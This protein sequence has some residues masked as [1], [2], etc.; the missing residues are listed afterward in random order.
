MNVVLSVNIPVPPT[1]KNYNNWLNSCQD[2]FGY[3]FDYS[4]VNYIS[5][6]QPI[7]V[8]CPE[9][10]EINTTPY[11]HKSSKHG[12]SKCGDVA[13]GLEQRR[14]SKEKFWLGVSRYHGTFYDYSNVIFEKITDRIEV[15]CPD[16]G[17][18]TITADHHMRGVSCSLCAN[19]NK[20]GGYTEQWFQADT[21]RKDI[22]GR[23]YLVE[24]FS[25]TERFLKIGMTRNTVKGR[26]AGCPYSYQ[27]LNE[28]P[29][30]LYN[31]FKIEEDLKSIKDHRYYPKLGL[32]KTESFKIEAKDLILERVNSY[33]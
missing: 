17:L 21:N 4:K 30:S 32:Y 3:R 1:S 2:K 20:K 24:M 23:L 13:M 18:F 11:R 25:N 10:G 26:Y 9:H 28:W 29:R 6:N 33:D 12:C 27:I 19:K 15:I 14:R 16:H 7:V 31:V 8:S 5:A 22:P